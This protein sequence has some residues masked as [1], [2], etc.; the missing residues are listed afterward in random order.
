[1]SIVSVS[2]YL[3]KDRGGFE[4]SYNKFKDRHSK[5]PWKIIMKGFK[6]LIEQDPDL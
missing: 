4:R 3:G 6:N 1:M 5:D 2:K